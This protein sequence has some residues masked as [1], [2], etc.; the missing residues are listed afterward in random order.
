MMKLRIIVVAMMLACFSCRE[1]D[2]HGNIVDTPTSGTITI[3]VDESLKP[4]IE[5]EVMAFEGIY[6]NAHIKA[7]YTS[8]TDAIN[9]LIQDSAR[10]AIVTRKL[11]D[12]EKEPFAKIQIKPDQ[13]NVGSGAVALILNKGNKDSL[14]RVT[15]LKEILTGKIT[16]WSQI[17]HSKNDSPIEVIF[18]NPASGIAR[19]LKDSIGGGQALP[20]N[21]FAVNNN[22]A[23]ID[24]V[25]KKSNAIGLIGSEWIADSSDAQANRFLSTIRVAALAGDSTYFLPYQAYIALKQYP[26]CRSTFMLSREARAGLGNGFIA[27]VSGEKGQR[28]FLKA[29]LVPATMPV[30]IV[31]INRTNN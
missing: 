31:E 11:T 20:P 13:V 6:R 17:N 26:L 12:K 23:V 2:K 15:Q 24:Y 3:A 7:V 9:M 18:D 27:F 19:F 21:C 16:K 14:I 30:R 4:L 29:G 25:S 28:I 5:A 1:K 22:E 8:E 10:L